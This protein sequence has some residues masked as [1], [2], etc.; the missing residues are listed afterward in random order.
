MTASY[1]RHR[2]L[3]A[4]TDALLTHE[5]RDS[6]AS[7]HREHLSDGA[8]A[9]CRGDL[10]RLLPVALDAAEQAWRE[11]SVEEERPLTQMEELYL[12]AR[13]PKGDER[14]AFAADWLRRHMDQ[15]N[16]PSSAP[17]DTP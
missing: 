12:I 8:C 16:P 11:A 4:A 13:M 5:W 10:A 7:A 3:T 2:M 6:A 14:T 1:V 17:G 9:V 15:E